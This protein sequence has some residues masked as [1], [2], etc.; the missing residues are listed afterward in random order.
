MKWIK[1]SPIQN[2]VRKPPRALEHVPHIHHL[3]HIYTTCT[4]CGSLFYIPQQEESY[5][6]DPSRKKQDFLLVNNPAY[7]KTAATQPMRSC[8]TP[9]RLALLL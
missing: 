1:E 7:E 9:Q 4:T 5:F 2:G 8:H 6:T 3:Y